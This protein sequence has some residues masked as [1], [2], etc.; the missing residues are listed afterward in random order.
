VRSKINNLDEPATM[1]AS[2]GDQEKMDEQ[3]NNVRGEM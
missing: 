1:H 2:F 3:I